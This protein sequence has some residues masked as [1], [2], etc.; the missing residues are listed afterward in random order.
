MKRLYI[1]ITLD[2]ALLEE[3]SRA[4]QLDEVGS[5][6]G[7]LPNLLSITARGPRSRFIRA[8]QDLFTS[9]INARKVV[10]RPI[11]FSSW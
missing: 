1:D 11:E 3:L 7:F 10:G 5:D 4:L 8:R 9:F 6:P 2:L